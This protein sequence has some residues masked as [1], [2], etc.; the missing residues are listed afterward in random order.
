MRQ[1]M[2]CL[3]GV[4]VFCVTV[5]WSTTVRGQ[6]PDQAPA[7]PRFAVRADREVLLALEE[8][9]RA[10][11]KKQY[12]PAVQLLQSVLDHGEDFFVEQALRRDGQDFRDNRDGRGG[13]K[14]V[15]LRMLKALPAEG[16]AA[17]ELEY[18]TEAR[19]E[20]AAA[21]DEGDLEGMAAVARRFPLT[22]AG[23]EATVA[24]AARAW[25]GQRPLEAALLLETVRQHP[26]AAQKRTPQLLLNLAACWSRAGRADRSLATLRDMKL[27]APG[28]K[29]RIGGRDVT[30]F[31]K[32]EEALAW[33]TTILGP[34]AGASTVLVDAWVM[35]GGG[36]TRNE[37]AVPASPVGGDRW[38]VS[39]FEHLAFD[40]REQQQQQR[41]TQLNELLTR[42]LDLLRDENRLTIPAA[43]PLVVGDAVVYRTIG[44]VTA[45]SL[46]TGEL[47]WRSALSDSTLVRLWNNRN[48][49][50]RAGEVR[51]V[52]AAVASNL[53]AHLRRRVFR[54]GA[55]GTLSTDGRTV[56]A[57]E[58]LDPLLATNPQWPG[59]HETTMTNKLVAYDLTGGRMLW[60][61]GGPRGA[62][63]VELSGHYFLGPPL[64][65][66]GRLYCL[67]ESQGD[68]R[69]MVLE[70][71]ADRGAVRLDWSQTLAAM[72]RPLSAHPMRRLAGL[73][74]SFAD[75]ILVCPTA[76]GAVIAVDTVRRV[77]LWGHSYRPVVPDDA[78]DAR[79]MAFQRINP[80]NLQLEDMDEAAR[81]LDAAPLIADGRA[82]VTPRDADELHCL[83]LLDG[84][85]LWKLPRGDWL[86]PA[87]LVD[88]RV[89]MVGR[90]GLAAYQLADGKPVDTFLTSSLVPSGRGVRVGS[91]Y[92]LPLATG[93]IATVDLRSG[94]ILARSKLSEG[95]VPGN[96]IA[97]G[98]AIVS[99]SAT[100]LTGFAR[101]GDIERQIADELKADARQPLALAL[102]GEL[103][104]HR[105]EEADG[106]ADLRDSLSLRPDPRVKSVLAAALLAGL[107]GNAKLI[108]ERAAELESLTDDPQ[109]RNEFL[110]LYARALEEAG[111]RRGAFAQLIRLAGTARYLN[112]LEA[113]STSHAVRTDRAIRARLIEMYQTASVEERAALDESLAKHIES[114]R[115]GAALDEHLDQSLRFFAG[116]PLVEQRL[117]AQVARVDGAA[118]PE[119]LLER[120]ALAADPAVAA[121]AT[122]LLARDLLQS[123]RAAAALPWIE[124]LRENY[125]DHKALD[126]STGRSLADQWRTRDDV[127]RLLNVTPV[128]TAGPIDVS[129]Q[130]REAILPA[131][132]P[133]EI[134]SRQGA[135]FRGW[136]FEID[137]SLRTLTARDDSSRVRWKATVPADT[138]HND[139]V[140]RNLPAP[141]QLH[142]RD[143]WLVLT[144]GSYFVVYESTDP[145][146][147]PR[148]A[149]QQTLR[150]SG[151]S[152]AEVMFAQQGMRVRVMPNGQ[153]VRLGGTVNGRSLG[154]FVGLTG[155]VALFI[156][157]QKLSA[158]ELDSGRLAWSRLDVVPGPVTASVDERAVVIQPSA[159][160]DLILL[161]TLD[162]ASLMK[163]SL[164]AADVV[165]WMRGTRL[166]SSKP[167]A[168]GTVVELRDIEQKRVVWTRT[169]APG[170]L[171]TT[172]DDEDVA[173]LEPDG[174]MT[175]VQLLS[176]HVRYETELPLK[177]QAPGAAPLGQPATWLTVQRNRDRDIVV[178][179]SASK[180]QNGTRAIPFDSSSAGSFPLDG[181]VCAVSQA[182]GRLLWA[183]PVE[184]TIFDRTQPAGLPVLLLA[185][186]HYDQARAAAN[187]FGNRFRI[188]ASVL[189]KRTGRTLYATEENA[190]AA[191]PRLEPD[192][193]HRRIVANFHDWQLDL[194]FP[195][196]DAKP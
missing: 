153:V 148:L 31:A 168:T 125:P 112:A 88:G 124:R 183:T 151:M 193:D 49:E 101:L 68:L 100:E 178:V 56:F 174:R 143:K 134:V 28:N 19:D 133:V 146:Q 132:M 129:R 172:V 38:R 45:V 82:V 15:A 69:L 141:C 29:L 175:A 7:A 130:P 177:W 163:Q 35:P 173:V 159:T 128:W 139:I 20:L 166:L 60:E 6:D 22:V 195:E 25:D 48:I 52:N 169:H 115:Q 136:S 162:G 154:Q 21:Q 1:T 104:L 76:S 53:A 26:V 4:M 118:H 179:G 140:G 72:D 108:H 89:V 107:H 37:S 111:D 73:S 181:H 10:V 117:F 65:L 97:G 90:D 196:P 171:L 157:G 144:V 75:G 152:Q 43:Q 13:V 156:V 64:P 18:G 24:L 46:S 145:Q 110:R 103:K 57:L 91:R 191:P 106:L 2:V 51:D 39:L 180:V 62:K 96:L 158:V 47:L 3:T 42:E 59:K 119:K 9:R 86:Y 34:A 84:R 184:Q 120:F 32:D 11:D 189:D 12:L 170:S 114:A 40:G 149:W 122:A 66:D 176:G 155:E 8:A 137:N 160:R 67:A 187:P 55:A 165:V 99:Q 127:Q 79:V 138:A 78:V 70:Q 36:P 58:E 27:L 131:D 116:L 92:F 194:T 105:G 54:D 83:D 50:T 135:T 123:N 186:R 87:C 150:T 161:R 16:H 182:D 126:D 121:Q 188:K 109:Q 44:D 80:V 185:A 85:L 94:Q 23:F 63:P 142:L 102:R 5:A 192:P 164:D 17:Y 95:R 167:L 98:G 113:R 77:L 71:E 81:W 33:L 74:P 61:I 190:P 93:E 14:A 30:L 147:A 41:R